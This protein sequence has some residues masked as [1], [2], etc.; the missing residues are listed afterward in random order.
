MSHLR[1]KVVPL[2]VLAWASAAS[3]HTR[4]TQPTPR[5]PADDIKDFNGGLA[6]C[7]DEPSAVPV[8]TLV[9][10]TLLRVTWDETVNH[11]GC[12]L[13]SLRVQREGTFEELANIKHSSALPAP[14][15]QNPRRYSADIQLP[16][17]TCDRCV[18]LMRQIML[19]S[20]TAQCPPASIPANVSYYSC[21]DL[22]LVASGDGGV[23]EPRPDAGTG[24]APEDAG[25]CGC[26]TSG[27][28]LIPLL[29]IGM[30]VLLRARRRTL[31]S[32]SALR[33]RCCA[34]RPGATAR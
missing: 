24:D 9:S 28:S 25:G 27:D 4:L 32:E 17:V 1:F 30:A 26:R 29:A 3:G 34:R 7:T 19:A 13:F 15:E 33:S 5:S 16:A 8:T 14:T 21:A 2:L 31:F 23:I 22:K 20:E 12:F 6:R 11:P 18:L 10:G